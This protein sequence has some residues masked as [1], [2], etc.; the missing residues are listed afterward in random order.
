MGHALLVSMLASGVGSFVAQLLLWPTRT[1]AEHRIVMEAVTYL[2]L[3]AGIEALRV[4]RL[5]RRR[6]R[7]V[8]S[9]P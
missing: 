9:R 8:T 2:G 4:R 1:H 5:L 6:D 3:L 7:D